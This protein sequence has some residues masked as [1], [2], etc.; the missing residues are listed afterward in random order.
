MCGL[1]VLTDRAEWVKTIAMPEL[2]STWASGRVGRRDGLVLAVATSWLVWE[3]S[4]RFDF[5]FGIRFHQ[6]HHLHN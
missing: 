2:H 4:G 1:A 6:S 5:H 3:D